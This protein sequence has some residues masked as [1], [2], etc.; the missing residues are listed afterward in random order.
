LI[1]ETDKGREGKGRGKFIIM[2][3]PRSFPDSILDV[4]EHPAKEEV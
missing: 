3:R 4:D 1:A 2:Q